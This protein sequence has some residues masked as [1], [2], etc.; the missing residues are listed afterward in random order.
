MSDEAG[1]CDAAFDALCQ[2]NDVRRKAS[3]TDHSDEIPFLER[4]LAISPS[5]YSAAGRRTMRQRLIILKAA[6]GLLP[7]K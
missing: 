2:A 5:P 1:G 4:E 7:L 3:P 6:A